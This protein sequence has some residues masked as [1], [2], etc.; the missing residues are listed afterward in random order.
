MTA[1]DRELE[2]FAA[3][4]VQCLE[5]LCEKGICENAT[6]R[7]FDINNFPLPSVE[8]DNYI[9]NVLRD[10]ALG[11]Q[12]VRQSPS[13]YETV[14]GCVQCWNEVI[15]TIISDDWVI[16]FSNADF[17][18]VR[19]E[20]FTTVSLPQSENWMVDNRLLAMGDTETNVYDFDVLPQWDDVSLVYTVRKCIRPFQFYN[21][22]LLRDV[23]EKMGYDDFS[24]KNRDII[25]YGMRNLTYE[26]QSNLIDCCQTGEAQVAVEDLKHFLKSRCVR[27][28]KSWG[29]TR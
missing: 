10:I 14:I 12:V 27:E 8:I 26:V 20:G 24:D 21:G 15:K 13:L 9:E 18:N 1:D 29:T 4:Y 25:Q 6:L 11:R 3:T 22:C 16:V 7:E 28:M 2:S 17:Y 5:D 19:Q 23:M